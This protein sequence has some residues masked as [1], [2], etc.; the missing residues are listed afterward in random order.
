VSA[1]DPEKRLTRLEGEFSGWRFTMMAITVILIAAVAFLGVKATR[2][3]TKLDRLDDRMRSGFAELRTE[4]A[5]QGQ[6]YA[7]S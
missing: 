7:A 2:I 5:N 6:H 1:A 4:I 3:D